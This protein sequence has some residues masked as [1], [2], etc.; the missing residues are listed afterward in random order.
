MT[1]VLLPQLLV[2]P[3]DD[4]V[5]GAAERIAAELT[6]A[7]RTR[8]E[9]RLGLAGG[10]TPRPIYEA[11]AAREDVDWGK[12]CFF[13]SDERAVGPEDEQSNFRMVRDV[14]FEPVAVVQN[15][16]FR[17]EGERP[18]PEAREAYEVAFGEQ[19]LDV[20]LLGMGGDGHTASVF[21]GAELNP[22]STQRVIVTESP[23]PPTARLS[24]SL[25]AINEAAQVILLVSGGAKA[26][27]LAEVHRQMSAGAPELPAAHVI[28]H[29]RRLL[30]IVDSDAAAAL[31]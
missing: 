25:R 12:V 14:L 23:I 30:W 15:R 13:F 7:I 2:L 1:D 3:A 16:V 18:P 28:P 22:A 8:G 24:L 29:S 20:L 9:C 31:P 27:R 5:A 21:P 19:P 10:G 6:R 26:T 11:L 4:F 17:I